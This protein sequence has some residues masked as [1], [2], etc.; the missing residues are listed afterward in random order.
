LDEISKRALALTLSLT[1]KDA[2]GQSVAPGSGFMIKEV[3]IINGLPDGLNEEAARALHKIRFKP[4][5]VGGENVP[6]WV[7]LEVEFYLR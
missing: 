6:N 7:V 4:A 5:T 3:R 1:G 2:D